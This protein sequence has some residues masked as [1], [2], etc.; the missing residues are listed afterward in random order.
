ME[1]LEGE[2]LSTRLSKGGLPVK[3]AVHIARQ[4]C[5]ALGAAHAVGIVHRDVKTENVLLLTRGGDPDYVKVLDFGVAKLLGG[6]GKGPM[7]STMDGAI[8]GTPSAMAPEQAAGDAVDH[9]I[10]VY[11]TGIVL[12]EMLTGRVPFEEGNFAAL[13]VKIMSAPPPPLPPRTPAGE[14]I[15]PALAALVLQ[16]LAKKPEHRPQS[17]AELSAALER[18]L[19]PGAT[20]VTVPGAA[21]PAEK[22]DDEALAKLAVPPSRRGLI[23]G[24]V[25]LVA[26]LGGGVWFVSDA[27]KPGPV[28]PGP[29]TVVTPPV[30]AAAV[31]AAVETPEVDA[32]AAEAEAPDAGPG[33]EPAVDAGLATTAGEPDAGE[34]KPKA[35]PLPPPVKLTSE[36]IL[37]VIRKATS[38]GSCIQRHQASL[39]AKKGAI[40]IAFTIEMSGK[41]SQVT[42]DPAQFTGKQLGPCLTNAV[43]ALRFPRH[44]GP[45]AKN[46]KIPYTYDFTGG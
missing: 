13:V 21:A 15:P 8:I 18:S 35:A 17:M 11:A 33:E 22:V 2:S 19:Q 23:A 9:R 29:V 24:L 39:P 44:V 30:P 20:P 4:L 16:C 26:L 36:H 7:V 45:A 41:V 37:S 42:V 46:A 14:P 38:L 43:K 6:E 12:Y 40:V 10:D 3:R 27:G 34:V 32:G 31:D 25:A 1:L 28:P 5:D